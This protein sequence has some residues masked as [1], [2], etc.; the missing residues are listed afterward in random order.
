VTKKIFS[1]LYVT[2]DTDWVPDYILEYCL[3]LL[4][5]NGIKATVF[6]THSS[7][8]LDNLDK[9][10]FEIGLHPNISDFSNAKLE[11][12]R[13]KEVFPYAVSLRSH[14]LCHSS[15]L[16]PILNELDI[17]LTSNYLAFLCKNLV[18]I[19]QP[20]GIIEYPIYFMD[21]A[22]EL[23]Y[24]GD[25]KYQLS[26]LNLFSPGMKILAFHPIHIFLNTNSIQRYK[27]S[28]HYQ[29]D[30]QK[31]RQFVNPGLGI[32]DLYKALIDFIAETSLETSRLSQE[33]HQ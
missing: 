14:S 23:M 24:D 9:N 28:K 1:E 25:D 27:E 31:L 3:G 7:R 10:I 20:F 16:Y 30:P 4:Q 32:G 12:S 26:S 13:L 6:A 5:V 22:Y 18:P 17:K 2:I 33:N 19:V 8:V 29:N 11:I 15:L 21:D